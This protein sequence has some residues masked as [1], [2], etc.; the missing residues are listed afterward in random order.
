MELTKCHEVRNGKY[1]FPRLALESNFKECSAHTTQSTLSIPILL[2]LYEAG[3][4]YF[5]GRLEPNLN[6]V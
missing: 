4:T 5:A 3:V 1:A 2:Y 6:I